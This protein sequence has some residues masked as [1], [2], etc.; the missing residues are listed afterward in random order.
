MPFE[1]NLLLRS[2][3]RLPKLA[4]RLLVAIAFLVVCSIATLGQA[5]STTSIAQQAATVPTPSAKNIE[6]DRKEA[7]RAAKESAKDQ[8]RKSKAEEK[9][10]LNRPAQIIINAPAERVRALIVSR[11]ASQGMTV[12]EA[13]DYKV[14]V[15]QRP[16]GWR[17]SMAIWIATYVIAEQEKGQTLVTVD[18]VRI[19]H[20]GN[21]TERVDLTKDKNARADIDNGLQSLKAL[22]QSQEAARE[23]KAM[24][25]TVP[26]TPAPASTSILSAEGYNQA[27]MG[28]FNQQRLPETEAAFRE[29]IRLD[30][31]NALYHHNLATA[32]NAQQKYEEAEKEADLAVRLAPNEAAYRKDLEIIR[33]NRRP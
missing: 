29:A 16:A 25:S 33:A 13:S 8:E 22:A 7:E 2:G 10:R 5:S 27:G 9:A 24:Q 23:Q 19:A 3:K 14:V 31:Y 17:R 30:T 28:L 11:A 1:I 26:P 6:R 20:L 32:L 12:E 15:S 4:V 18:L 21:Y